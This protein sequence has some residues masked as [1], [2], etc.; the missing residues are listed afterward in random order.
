LGYAS[1][2][3]QIAESR[4]VH[5]IW[6]HSAKFV[7]RM[8]VLVVGMF[9]LIVGIIMIFTPGPAIV[10]IPAGLA[11]LATEFQWARRLLQRVRPMIEAGIEKARQKKEAVAKR[12]AQ[13][14]AARVQARENARQAEKS[15]PASAA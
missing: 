6:T 7:W 2:S 15:H 1:V 3:S 8:G 12:R 9:L 4:P 11:V 13:K 14:Q 5:R 10:F